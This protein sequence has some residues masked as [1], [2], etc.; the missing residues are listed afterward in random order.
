MGKL[1]EVII[2]TA[3][4]SKYADPL[5]DILDADKICSYRLFR[6]HCTLLNGVYVKELKRLNRNPKNLILLDV[7][8]INNKRIILL[9]II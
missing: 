6:E 3:S 1:Y 4:L 8:S 7:N 2:F 5:I 9:V